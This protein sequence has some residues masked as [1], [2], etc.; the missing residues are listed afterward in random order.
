LLSSIRRPRGAIGLASILTIVLLLI[1]YTMWAGDNG[2]PSIRSYST[3]TTEQHATAWAVA[4]LG[5]VISPNQAAQ[6]VGSLPLPT[7]LP[8]NLQ[9]S[10]IRGDAVSVSLLYTSPVVP[11]IPNWD[12]NFSVLVNIA[13]DNTSYEQFPPYQVSGQA[14]LSCTTNSSGPVQCTTMSE[15]VVTSSQSPIKNI[16]ISGHPGHGWDPQ[17]QFGIGVVTWWV[18]G[19]HYTISGDLPMLTL[20]AIAGSMNT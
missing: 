13:R 11:P 1:A 5:P 8:D 10:Q 7:V 15:T 19:V 16:V 14:I 6:I 12:Q 2:N 18:N 17:G 4:S 3:I 9:L 20:E